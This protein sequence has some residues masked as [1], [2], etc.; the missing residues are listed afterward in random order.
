MQAMADVLSA[1]SAAV[2]AADKVVELIHR[3]PAC[4][5]PG[6]LMPASF[7]GRLQL[8]EVEFRYPARPD[9]L[10][11]DRL[12]LQVN[13]G[14]VR[15]RLAGC[16]PCLHAP[17]RGCHASDAG[18]AFMWRRPAALQHTRQLL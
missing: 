8:S 9:T 1:L 14:E 3:P 11:L 12:S 10:V 15:Q 17:A 2:G 6:T 4:P 16:G 13:P 7:Q 5:P 18:N